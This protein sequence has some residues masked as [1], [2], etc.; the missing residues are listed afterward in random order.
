MKVTL[1]RQSL[2]SGISLV[3]NSVA[4]SGTLPIL[5]NVMFDARR[6]GL[7]LVT[8]DLES[9]ARVGLEARVEEAGQAT[10]P[11]KMVADIARLSPD[12]EM[13]I[14]AEGGRM[15]LTCNRNVYHLATMDAGDFPVWPKMEA[16]T[17][18]TVKQADLR[19]LLRHTLFAMPTRDPRKVLM[20]VLFELANEKLT[21]VATDGRKLGRCT[22]E[23]TEIKGDVE[24]QAIIPG[25]VLGEIERALGDEGEA[26]IELSAQRATHSLSNLKLTYLTSLVDGKFPQYQAV[27][28]ESYT[29]TLELPKNL[30]DEVI[31]RA[32]ILAE[33]KHH[34]IVLDFTRKGIQIRAESYEGGSF[35]G[36]IELEVD[37]EPFKIAFNHQYLHDVFRVAPDSRITM[38]VKDSSAPVV[39]E[40][41]S[42]PDSLFLVMPVRVHDLENPTEAETAEAAH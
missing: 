4:A 20:G 25:R 41:E 31:S 33:R 5:S 13:A 27:I 30:V 26:V 37:C 10:A 15:T 39:F 16:A 12:G 19:R 3:Q 22:I 2:L 36:E 34:S 7:E 9:F 18:V 29:R 24:A 28:P 11:A 23:P 21:G 42:D 8:T 6:G 38:K 40:C 1:S 35:E 17:T 32:G 14:V